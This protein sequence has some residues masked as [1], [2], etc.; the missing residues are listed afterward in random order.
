MDELYTIFRYLVNAVYFILGAIALFGLVKLHL[1]RKKV[2]LSKPKVLLFVIVLSCIARLSLDL[3]PDDYYEAN[4]N[5]L[6]IL[7][8]ILDLLPELLFFSGYFMLLIMWIELYYL[9]KIKDQPKVITRMWVLYIITIGVMFV[10]GFIFAIGVGASGPY[11]PEHLEWEVVFLAT[12]SL[13]LTISFPVGGWYLFRQLKEANTITSLKKSIMLTQLQRM[14]VV[15]ILC[16]F[17]HMTYTLIL[18]IY[19][20]GLIENTT[21]REVLW[22]LYFVFTEQLPTA[23]IIYLLFRITIAKVSSHKTKVKVEGK[24]LQ[25]LISD[26]DISTQEDTNVEFT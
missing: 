13:T 19:F 7:Q 10:A 3:I 11:S 8:M 26:K 4:I 15:V 6:P 2:L 24:L 9:T 17:A 20:K 21:V 14:L 25:P 22:L 16:S 12:L 23:L 1:R 18:E 5:S